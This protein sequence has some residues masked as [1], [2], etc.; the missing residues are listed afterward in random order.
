[1][2]RVQGWQVRVQGWQVRV[3]GWQVRVVVC[4]RSC[5]MCYRS[6]RVCYQP[7]MAG[8][9][10]YLPPQNA[11]YQTFIARTGHTTILP[12]RPTHVPDR[13]THVPGVTSM[14]ATSRTRLKNKIVNPNLA[15]PQP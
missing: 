2:V 12:D 9:C 7:R 1:M 5:V 6:P 13:P 3:Q 15:N 4:Y 8:K 14:H 11:S 10:S